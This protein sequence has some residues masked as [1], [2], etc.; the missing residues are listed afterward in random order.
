[1]IALKSN[2]SQLNNKGFTLVELIIVIVLLGILSATAF[3]HFI[4]LSSDARIKVITQIKASVKTANDLLYLKSFMSSYSTRAVPGRP[5]L[6]DIDMDHDGD[7]D[8]FGANKVDVRLKYHYIDNT[9][10]IKR[11]NISDDFLLKEE[12][13]DFTYIGYDLD[14]NGQVKNDNCYFKYTQAQSESVPAAYLVI[15]SSC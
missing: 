7:F 14:N 6:I 1:M 15:S 10:I 13:I 3:P 12:G 9:D 11:I 2:F 5:D 4:N 8:V